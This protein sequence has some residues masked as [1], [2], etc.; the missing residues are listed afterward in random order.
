MK[1]VNSESIKKL[2]THK[3]KNAIE[4]M[5][6]YHN[7]ELTIQEKQ[8]LGAFTPLNLSNTQQLALSFFTIQYFKG[9]IN[10]GLLDILGI[11]QEGKVTDENVFE[12]VQTHKRR[13]L[14]IY[15]NNLENRKFSGGMKIYLVHLMA[16]EP[17]ERLMELSG[18]VKP[19]ASELRLLKELEEDYKLKSPVINV[20][21]EY[22]LL[23]TDMKLSSN[24]VKK[25]ASHW[26]RKNIYTAEEAMRFAQKEH[27]TYQ[28]TVKDETSVKVENGRYIKMFAYHQTYKKFTDIVR[29][30][31]FKTDDEAFKYMVD[32]LHKEISE[33]PDTSTPPETL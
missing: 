19:N 13:F 8:I 18:G 3:D 11:L 29:H 28:A 23:K 24:Y 2:L 20:L 9:E 25:I 15:V 6:F 5:E 30:N 27:Q 31:G 7:R 1:T 32:R 12:Y 17:D 26:K 14:E 4:F 16:V 21:I 33:E 22:V 10:N